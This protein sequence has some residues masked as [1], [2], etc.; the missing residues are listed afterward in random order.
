MATDVSAPLPDL[1]LPPGATITVEL[2]DASA[3]VT[4]LNVYGFSPTTGQ[5]ES[6]TVVQPMFPYA[7]PGT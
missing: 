5:Q 3:I 7:P 2:D 1:I 4:Q 6:V